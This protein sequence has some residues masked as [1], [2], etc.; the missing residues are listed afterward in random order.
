[1]LRY[2]RYQGVTGSFDGTK[3]LV[4]GATVSSVDLEPLRAWTDLAGATTC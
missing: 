2:R 3:Q 1:M 4:R